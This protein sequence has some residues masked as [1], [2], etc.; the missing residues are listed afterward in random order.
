MR[1]FKDNMLDNAI[2]LP[3]AIYNISLFRDCMLYFKI[4][5]DSFVIK[6]MP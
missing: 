3:Y 5:K 6:Y 2:E 1:N 4:K